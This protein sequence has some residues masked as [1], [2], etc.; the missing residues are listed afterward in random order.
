MM[1][2]GRWH[3]VDYGSVERTELTAA[4]VAIVELYNQLSVPS[5]VGEQM[6]SA[7]L[8]RARMV[9]PKDFFQGHVTQEHFSLKFIFVGDLPGPL[10]IG[11]GKSELFELA[12]GISRQAANSLTCLRQIE[13]GALS[14]ASRNQRQLTK[15]LKGFVSPLL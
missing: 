1:S 5:R 2:F 3:A 15:Q 9:P 6:K 8:R 4:G 14:K 7:I 10:F 13:P 12:V 11:Q